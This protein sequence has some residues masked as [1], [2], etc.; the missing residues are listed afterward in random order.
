MTGA[1]RGIGRAIA[2][3]LATEGMDVAICA[4]DP[5]GV[6]EAVA[7]LRAHGGRVVGYACDV[8][9][10]DALRRT[11]DEA[12]AALGRLDVLVC[13]ASALAYGTDEAAWQAS[14]DV[15]LMH[16]VRAC[17]QAVPHLERDG[18]GAIVL[19]SS[20]SGMLPD[21]NA[22]GPLKA[23]LIAHGRGLAERLGPRGVR[24]NVVAPGS[25]DFAGGFW[26][27]RRVAEPEVYAA[28]AARSAL[29]RHGRPEEV[30]AVVAFLASPRASLVTGTLVR[31]DGGQWKA[32]H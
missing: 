25:V 23:A 31:A 26:D 20:I 9:D 13:N 8:A 19:V 16:A 11:V 3:A 12:A 2:E 1:S 4:R 5:A 15:D 21:A 17:D 24:V 29:G 32:T 14:V 27:R 28:T 7:A 22:Y 10:G 30:A 6:E 18:G